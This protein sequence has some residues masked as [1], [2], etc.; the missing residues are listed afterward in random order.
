M[1]AKI[2]LNAASGGGSFSLQAPSSSSNNR[3]FTIP[4]VADGTIATTA[5]AGKILQVVQTVKKSRFSMTGSTFTDITGMSVTI[6]PTAASSKILITSTG[7]FSGSQDSM[8]SHCRLGRS[9]NSGSFDFTI[10]LGD[11]SSSETQSSIDMSIGDISNTYSN[12]MTR[13]FSFGFLDSPSYSLG[14]AIVYKLDVKTTNGGTFVLGGSS[15]AGD[16]NSR[17]APAF[18]TAM[19]VAV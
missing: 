8:Y 3:V 9:I 16:S 10:I 1:T 12:A 2:K 4:D 14:N 19:E 11:Q 17:S 18:L 6:T 5:T 13:S 15:Y 7:I